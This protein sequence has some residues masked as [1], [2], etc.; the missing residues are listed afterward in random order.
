MMPRAA[1]AL[2]LVGL[3][4]PGPAHS[5]SASLER[6][7][8]ALVRVQMVPRAASRR[9]AAPTLLALRGGYDDDDTAEAA[10]ER[11]ARGHRRTPDAGGR[12]PRGAADNDSQRQRTGIHHA[13]GVGDEKKRVFI[14]RSDDGGGEPGSSV[15]R[16]QGVY[17]A[18]EDIND[19]FDSEF[20][21][22]ARSREP[23]I[24]AGDGATP[25]GKSTS[26]RE[27]WSEHVPGIGA[28]ALSQRSQAGGGDGMG[29]AFRLD[30]MRELLEAGKVDE[31]KMTPAHTL[32]VHTHPLPA[33][34]L[35]PHPPPSTPI[36]NP[37]T[38][39]NV[40]THKHTHTHTHTHNHPHTQPPTHTHPHRLSST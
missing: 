26:A 32:S 4:P 39:T 17:S 19:A 3:G 23:G 24:T 14:R 25:Q 31:V 35:H 40:H 20:R 16:G 6:G 34:H 10:R 37:P 27:G 30:K 8:P 11:A 38:Q 36:H 28:G 13:E 22:R 18:L 2:L 7:G 5:F 12:P 1:L 9:N 29:S 15:G 33:T 21:Q